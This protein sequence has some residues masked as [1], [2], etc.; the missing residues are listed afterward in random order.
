[1]TAMIAMTTPTRRYNRPIRDIRTHPSRLA[2]TIFL[3]LRNFFALGLALVMLTMLA[4]CASKAPPQ[5]QY[6]FGPLPA[7]SGTLAWSPAWPPISVADLNTPAWLDSPMMLFRLSYAND[8]QTRPYAGSRWNMP[9]AQ[10][11][12]QR[13][14]SRLAQ[15]GAKV[16]SATDGNPGV[17]LLRIDADDFI[18]TFESPGQSSAVVTM[19]A[20]LFDSRALLAQKTFTRQVAATSPDAPGGA[21]ALAQASDALIG[22]MIAWLAQTPLPI[23]AS[24]LVKPVP[25]K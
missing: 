14:K 13:L 11:F 1:M 23:P 2:M 19:R 6:D 9:P 10:L 12:G 5:T 18:Q 20:S 8:Q 25:M 4:G 22:D 17:P 16:L 3:Q 24:M 7:A 15:A 21:R